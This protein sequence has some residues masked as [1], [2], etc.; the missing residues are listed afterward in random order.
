MKKTIIVTEKEWTAIYNALREAESK[1]LG[2]D[3]PTPAEEKVLA[4]IQAAIKAVQKA[5]DAPVQP[6]PRRNYK[7][8]QRVLG[9]KEFNCE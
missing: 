4:G 6:K 9:K 1:R 3:Y 7:P 2:E 5:T 8:D